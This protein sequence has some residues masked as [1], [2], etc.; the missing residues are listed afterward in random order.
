MGAGISFTASPTPESGVVATTST[1]EA[2]ALTASVTAWQT[3]E[4][5]AAIAAAALLV[6]AVVAVPAFIRAWRE[7]RCGDI[8]GHLVRALITTATT[9]VATAGIVAWAHTL[10]A[11]ERENAAWPYALAFA[12]WAGL[13][14]LCAVSWSALLVGVAPLGD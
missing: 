6:G 1:L 10:S 11:S 9:L 8:R 12:G 14:A 7:G 3:V 13:V 5:A 4:I 2:V